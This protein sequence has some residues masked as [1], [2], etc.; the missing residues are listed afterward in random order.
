MGGNIFYQ[1][2][3]PVPERVPRL[4]PLHNSCTSVG[5][6]DAMP[7]GGARA[8]RCEFISQRVLLKLFCKSHFPHK[9]V[10]LL[11]VLIVI[12]NKS[13]DLCGNRLLLIDVISSSCE[14][15][16]AGRMLNAVRTP[17]NAVS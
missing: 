17:S 11:F 6:P 1:R 8:K 7:G 3:T 2:G 9:S 16:D 14:I 4:T 5:T 15:R 10:N 13:M 12:K